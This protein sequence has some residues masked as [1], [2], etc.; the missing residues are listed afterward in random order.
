MTTIPKHQRW[1]LA[2]AWL[3]APLHIPGILD[4]IREYHDGIE[5]YRVKFPDTLLNSAICALPNGLLSCVCASGLIGIYRNRELLR[6]FGPPKDIFKLIRGL[7][8][9]PNGAIA[10]ATREIICIWNFDGVDKSIREWAIQDAEKLVALS[11]GS[12]AVAHV[13]SVSIWDPDTGKLVYM[14]NLCGNVTH[15]VAL[16]GARLAIAC[17][18]HKEFCWEHHIDIW[19]EGCII[20]KIVHPQYI[21]MLAEFNGKLAVGGVD[22]FVYVWDEFLER[23]SKYSCAD[24]LWCDYAMG[25]APNGLVASYSAGTLRIW[26][27]YTGKLIQTLH[28][29]ERAYEI[30]WHSDYLLVSTIDGV[31]MWF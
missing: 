26:E 22:G 19:C 29:V 12:L 16:P 25:L 24:A 4:I 14:V 9:L 21:V 15:L 13:R 7:A 28:G 5:G 2:K 31:L 8:G 3:L 6:T 27:L 18:V 30:I 11:D 20:K 17:W 1:Q 23:S 10:S